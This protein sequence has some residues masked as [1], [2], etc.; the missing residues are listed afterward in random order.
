MT[1]QEVRKKTRELIRRSASDMRK[2][3]ERVLKSGAINLEEY[4]DSYLLPKI[5]IIALLKEEIFQHE[6][7]ESFRKEAMK[8]VDNIF[9]LL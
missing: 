3:I 1:R 6:P 7:P 8:E 9:A 4:E 2:N 5:I